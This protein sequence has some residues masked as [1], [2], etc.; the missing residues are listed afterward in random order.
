MLG[1]GPSRRLLG[2]GEWGWGTGRLH[3][4]AAPARDAAMFAPLLPDATTGR[5]RVGKVG[6]CAG[7][8]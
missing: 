6:G 8:V 2:L 5:Q 4:V 3:V 7:P 1:V